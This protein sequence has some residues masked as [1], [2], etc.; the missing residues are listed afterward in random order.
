MEVTLKRNGNGNGNESEERRASVAP[1][2]P[3][4]DGAFVVVLRIPFHGGAA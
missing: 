2:S 1:L 3:G 4:L